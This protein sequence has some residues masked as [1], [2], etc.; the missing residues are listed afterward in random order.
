MK[1][2]KHFFL[3]VVLLAGAGLLVAAGCAAST[4]EKKE[5]VE[6]RISLDIGSRTQF[7]VLRITDPDL[8]RK[9][10]EDPLRKARPDPNPARYEILGSVKLENK[11]GTDDGFVFFCP[12]GRCKVGDKYLIADF[13]ALRKEFKEAID[14]AKKNLERL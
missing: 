1:L 3:L 12:W 4:K 9:L 14:R 6:C 7:V 2:V 11:D 10:I 8:I 13:S 5:I